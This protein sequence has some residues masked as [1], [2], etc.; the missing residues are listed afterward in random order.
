MKPSPPFIK[1]LRDIKLE[2]YYLNKPAELYRTRR[3]LGKATGTEK[4]GINY[5]HLQPG[6]LS[7]KY[8][9]HTR[10]EE[11]FHILRGKAVLRRGAEEYHLETGDSAAILPG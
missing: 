8:H 3:R 11:F 6:K 1:H 4:I 2:P 7:S 9:Y 10:E 5:C